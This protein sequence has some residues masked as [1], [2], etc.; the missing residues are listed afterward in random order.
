MSDKDP[1]TQLVMGVTELQARGFLISVLKRSEELRREFIEKYLP[2]A[3]PP[4]TP[5]EELEAMPGILG[6]QVAEQLSPEGLL[7][8]RYPARSGLRKRTESEAFRLA[9]DRAFGRAK[10]YAL[11][12][13]KQGR[14][15]AAALFSLRAGREMTRGFVRSGSLRDWSAWDRRGLW[16]EMLGMLGAE[17]RASVIETLLSAWESG[18]EGSFSDAEALFLCGLATAAS[19]ARFFSVIDRRI[20]SERGSSEFRNSAELP[21]AVRC[22]AAV[23]WAT[24]YGEASIGAWIR[25]G[26]HDCAFAYAHEA[27]AAETAGNRAW[28][29]ELCRR[30]LGFGI[31]ATERPRWHSRITRLQR[32]SGDEKGAVATLIEADDRDAASPE[33]LALLK[34]ALPKDEWKKRLSRWYRNVLRRPD[35]YPG[36][37]TVCRFLRDAGEEKALMLA[38]TLSGRKKI[39]LEH[40]DVL[41]KTYVHEAAG[42]LLSHLS[43]DL[44]ESP[45]PGRV[46]R[47]VRS[48]ELFES[49]ARTLDLT[50]RLHCQRMRTLHVARQIALQNKDSKVF[51]AVWIKYGFLRRADL[52]ALG[53]DIAGKP[54]A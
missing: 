17:G 19:R 48:R 36:A 31:P 35:A 49:W 32:E 3:P 27:D 53:V 14:P 16:E 15:E 41:Q 34:A 50:K 7:R 21:A 2:P 5:E 9:S 24:G 37:E 11:S 38:S 44:P 33:D 13:A 30:V 47:R 52:E 46:P 54:A 51:L 8:I 29:I 40:L 22:R 10:A 18:K 20:E 6:D 45:L 39:V 4:L 43:D 1:V 26:F 42:F 28:A 25:A 23:M 12:W